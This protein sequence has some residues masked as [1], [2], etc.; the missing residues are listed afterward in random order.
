MSTF[1]ELLERHLDYLSQVGRTESARIRGFESPADVVQG[2]VASLLERGERD[3]RDF[4][5]TAFKRYLRVT[6]RNY[7]YNRRKYYQVDGR[8]LRPLLNLENYPGKGSMPSSQVTF[9]EQWD[10][11]QGA[12]ARMSLRSLD[13]L[14][15]KLRG[16][17]ATE[18]AK[19]LAFPTVMAARRARGRALKRLEVALGDSGSQVKLT[20]KSE[21]NADAE[22]RRRAFAFG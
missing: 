2:V 11:L 16:E 20:A 12:L 9:S 21:G 13:L 10:L 17:S 8:D 7:V 18:L 19:R 3:F 14:I 22:G 5:E 6:M 4:G 1:R 15:S